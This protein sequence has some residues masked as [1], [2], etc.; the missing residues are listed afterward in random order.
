MTSYFMASY[1]MTHA[2]CMMHDD[3]YDIIH[4]D[5][6]IYIYIFSYVIMSYIMTS[7]VMLSFVIT[8]YVMM[9]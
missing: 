1:A 2:R 3:I 9:S 7:Y 6:M 5:F 4:H 8:P